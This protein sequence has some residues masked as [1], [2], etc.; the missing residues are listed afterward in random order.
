[1][2]EEISKE[3]KPNPDWIEPEDGEFCGAYLGRDGNIMIA[4]WCTNQHRAVIQTITPE[5]G[6]AKE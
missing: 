6:E 2:S 3:D 1:M 5:P 4:R